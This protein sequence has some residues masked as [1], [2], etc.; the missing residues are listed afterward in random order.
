MDKQ[1]IIDTY[2]R[3]RI[4][5]A[6]GRLLYSVVFVSEMAEDLMSAKATRLVD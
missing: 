4:L 3:R 1:T 6:A 2:T 5:Y